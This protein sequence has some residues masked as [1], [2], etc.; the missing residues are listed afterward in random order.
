[1]TKRIALIVLL[2]VLLSL[3]VSFFFAAKLSAPVWYILAFAVLQSLGASLIPAAFG[4]VVL[5]TSRSRR[6]GGLKPAVVA[7]VVV[8][9]ITSQAALYPLFRG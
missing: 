4:V 3:P 2:G 6:D 7:L 9:V 5:I 8:S 1:M